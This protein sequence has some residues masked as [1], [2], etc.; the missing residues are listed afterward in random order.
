MGIGFAIPSNMVRVTVESLLSE[1]RAVRPWFGAGG[2]AVTN[3]IAQSLGMDRPVG[4]L[5]NEIYPGGRPIA[6]A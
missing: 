1:G 3:D 4:V 2:Q 5:I 6:L